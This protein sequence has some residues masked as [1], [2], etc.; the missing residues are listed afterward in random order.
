MIRSLHSM[1][2]TVTVFDNRGLTVRN[3]AYHRHPGSPDVTSERITRHQ[4]DARGFLMR[5]A[6][7]RLHEGG[8][9]NFSYLTDL[10]G[11]PLRTQSVD[12]GITITLNDA[13]GRPFISVSK[14]STADDGTEDR[15]QAVTRTW[16]YENAGLPGR[17][18][19]VTEQVTGE[20]ARITERF[21]YAGNS[22]AEKALNLVGACVSY[23]DTAGMMQTDSIAITGVP[24]SVTRH[25]LK[26]AD[27]PDVVADWQG[28]DASAWNDL[29]DGEVYATVVTADSTGAIL[30]TIDAKGNMQRVAYD[31]AGLLLGSWL[32][33]KDNTEQVIV[34]SL[35][36]S[37]TG[38]KL[39]EEHGNGVVTT[40]TYE[41]ETQ[42]LTG[43]KTERPAGHTSGAKVLQDLRYEYDPVGNVLII[44]NDAEETRF[45]RNQKVVPANTYVYDS[46]YQLV[47]ATGRE[48]ANTGHQSSSILPAAIVPLPTDNSTYT[49]YTRTY[50][51]DNGGNLTQIRHSAPATNN[52]YTTA[53]TVSDRSNRGVL[54]TL[55]ENPAEVDALFSASGQQK[56]LQ[57]GQHLVWTT[58][59]ELLK[60]A[61]VLREGDVAD[62]EGYRYDAS[63]QRVLKVS[64][65]KTGNST[66]RQSALYL[67]GL[68]LRTTTRGTAET[69][70]LQIITVGEAGRAQVR[71]LYWESG[72]PDG[73]VNGQLRYSYDNLT[74]SS[75]LELDGYGNIISMEEYYPYGGTAVWTARSV[76]EAE[77]KFIRYSGK[78]RDATGLYYYGYR[79]Y[80]PWTGRWLSADPAGTVDGLNLF[81]MVGNNPVTFFD[82]NGLN[83]TE[84]INEYAEFIA[85]AKNSVYKISTYVDVLSHPTTRMVAAE[86]RATTRRTTTYGAKI[87]G[88]AAGAAAG[89]AIGLTFPISGPIVIGT[90]ALGT[91]AGS[92]AAGIASEK[93]FD[94][95]VNAIFDKNKFQPVRIQTRKLKDAL[96]KVGG[97][98]LVNS[99]KDQLDWRD[100][101]INNA[102]SQ[103]SSQIA[104]YLGGKLPI[105]DM[106]NTTLEI[107]DFKGLTIAKRDKIIS[108]LDTISER[109]SNDAHEEIMNFFDEKG[110][111]SV[112]KRGAY[113]TGYLLAS[114]YNKD[115]LSNDRVTLLNKVR[116]VRMMLQ[117][118]KIYRGEEAKKLVARRGVID[119]PS[120]I[121]RRASM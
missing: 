74:G 26:D 110:T 63:S 98:S 30:T 75:I 10:G 40:Y 39:R 76:M 80:Q 47:S 9:V 41:P 67:P 73:I 59:N 118:P 19:S 71:V 28:E 114:R 109:L 33:L 50:T 93:F 87:A 38:Q 103:A 82:S 81:R 69:E 7:P 60:V 117:N 31:V 23:Y 119:H 113:Y 57:P 35:T 88:A 55:T 56:Q 43:I 46:L 95:G 115:T 32:T 64:M 20:A 90:A 105:K 12:A 29:L 86:L 99:L 97:N 6:D 78:E 54:S 21:V 49:S 61:P 84:R 62:H 101:L 4:Y 37:A 83:R 53:I 89:G 17:P 111:N 58:R 102:T 108:I 112:R 18:V 1:I 68:E 13:A 25:L 72:R 52:N 27:I 42:R 91:L 14:I 3:I 11:S 24:L 96:D 70:S 5:S 44:T 65:Q 120:I 116:D 100:Q 45:W 121:S 2:P 48:M 16:Q 85:V 107:I 79:Y 36:Y 51:Y 66:Q 8:L 15:S 77:Y 94:W 22:D 92:I 106:F 104:K 34:K